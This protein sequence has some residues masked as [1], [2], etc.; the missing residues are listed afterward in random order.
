VREKV[1]KTAIGRGIRKCGKG[2]GGDIPAIRS[3]VS[4]AAPRCTPARP[5][6]GRQLSFHYRSAKAEVAQSFRIAIHST[7]ISTFLSRETKGFPWLVRR[8]F[9]VKDLFEPSMNGKARAKF[10]FITTMAC[11]CKSAQKMG[12]AAHAG[13]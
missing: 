7:I 11:R 9:S 13:M 5:S 4:P 12:P 3:E 1:N 10:L 6:N 8:L 2:A